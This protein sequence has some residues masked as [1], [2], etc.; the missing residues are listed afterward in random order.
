MF[1][2]DNVNGFPDLEYIDEE[3]IGLPNPNIEEM[4]DEIIAIMSNN[5]KWNDNEIIFY[6]YI[7][8]KKTFSIYTVSNRNDN[9]AEFLLDFDSG[10]PLELEENPFL[11]LDQM[12]NVKRYFYINYILV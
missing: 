11:I 12:V 5:D 9:S 6:L 7:Y 4:K 1:D 10:D 3:P 2:D 8:R